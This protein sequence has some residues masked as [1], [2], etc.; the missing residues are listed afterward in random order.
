[1]EQ[2]ENHKENIKKS[3]Q[4]NE[5]DWMRDASDQYMNAFAMFVTRMSA[6]IE[7]EA[8]KYG[9]EYIEMEEELFGAVAEKVMKS[10]GNGSIL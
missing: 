4:E 7:Q 8:E 10:F 2:G 6:Y 9:F 1:V 3:A 5:H